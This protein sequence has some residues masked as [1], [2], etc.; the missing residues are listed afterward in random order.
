[1]KKNT[2]EFRC[3]TLYSDAEETQVAYPRVPWFSC[4]PAGCSRETWS[5]RTEE[6]GVRKERATHDVLRLLL[7]GVRGV[8]N[9]LLSDLR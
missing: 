8:V 1:M 3:F 6:E 4:E 7:P 2:A 5:A 9:L